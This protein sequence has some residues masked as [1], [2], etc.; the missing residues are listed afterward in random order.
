[1]IDKLT[2]LWTSDDEETALNMILMYL[3]KSNTNGWWKEC[4]LITWGPS[5]KLLCSSKLVQEQVR[6]CMEQGV[7]MYACQRC[8]EKYELV[9][10]IT[11]MGIELKLMGEPFTEFL[12]DET[13]RVIT[14]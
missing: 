7:K 14:I 4:N 9:D 5:N 11:N 13:T 2:V 1:M 3:L 10:Q 8:A 12:K 6:A